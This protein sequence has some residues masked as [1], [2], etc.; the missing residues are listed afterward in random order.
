MA[1]SIARR[2]VLPLEHQIKNKRYEKFMLFNY[3]VHRDLFMF[4]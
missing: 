1:N 3:F 2:G 4:G